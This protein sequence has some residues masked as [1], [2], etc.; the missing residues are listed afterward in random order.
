[1]AV[2]ASNRRNVSG[3]SRSRRT[4][5]PREK[6]ARGAGI[7]DRHK[8]LRPWILPSLAGVAIIAIVLVGASAIASGS[9]Q[10]G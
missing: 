10:G 6:R 1:M 2:H 8:G 5:K 9:D 4:D 3:K 7:G